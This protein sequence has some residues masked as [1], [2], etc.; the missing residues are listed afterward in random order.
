MSKNTY[1]IAMDGPVGAGKSTLARICAANLGFVY[2]D[3]GALY[4]AVALFCH[5]NGI[6]IENVQGV[7]SALDNINIVLEKGE[8]A[9]KVLLNGED[10]SEG[11]RIPEVSLMASAVSAI[12]QVREFLLDMQRSFAKTQNVIMDGRDI[13]TV[14]LPNADLKLF[15]TTDAKIRAKRRFDELAA[16]GI[17]VTFEEVLDDLQ[18]RDFNDMNR[19]IAPLKQADDAF[20]IDTGEM[21][22][23]QS[24]LYV[25]S[26]IKEKL[27]L[28]V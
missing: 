19:E 3:T 2:I 1:S 13:G 8:N 14:I 25:L 11:I 17:T 9:Q 28:N 27:N 18:T 12:P 6:E 5:R 21:N 23:E 15:I 20:L 10:V 16:K 7:V 24:V 26:F 4:R 22:L